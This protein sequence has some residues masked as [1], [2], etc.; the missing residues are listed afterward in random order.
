MPEEKQFQI[1]MP[2]VHDKCPVCGSTARLGQAAINQF[3]SQ[4]ILPKEAFGG[5]GLLLQARLFDPHHPPV[6]IT[7][8][9]I[10]KVIQVHWDVCG[11]YPDK[12][13]GTIYCTR[14]E[15]L[16]QVADVQLIP[17]PPVDPTKH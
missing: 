8:T 11:G 2:I 17:G 12:P 4:G 13:C 3:K 9:I 7:P 16:D 1:K 15:I 6:V 14:F 5:G 10:V